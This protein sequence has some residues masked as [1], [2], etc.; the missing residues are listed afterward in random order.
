MGNNLIYTLDTDPLSDHL[1]ESAEHLDDLSKQF[2]AA[3]TALP[4]GCHEHYPPHDSLVGSVNQQIYSWT[5]LDKALECLVDLIAKHGNH[6][7][8]LHTPSGTRDLYVV[9]LRDANGDVHYDRICEESKAIAVNYNP[10]FVLLD[11]IEAPGDYYTA[12]SRQWR[13]AIIANIP[14][15][16]RSIDFSASVT[17]KWIELSAEL[18]YDKEVLHSGK[19]LLRFQVSGKVAAAIKK[20]ASVGVEGGFYLEHEFDTEAEANAFLDQLKAAAIKDLGKAAIPLLGTT[21]FSLTGSDTVKHLLDRGSLENV[22]A[23]GGVVAEVD[24][25]LPDWSSLEFEF[26]ASLGFFYGYDFLAKE[27]ILR[28]ESGIGLELEV[29]SFQGSLEVEFEAELHMSNQ[30]DS[31]VEASFSID[32]QGG[33]ESDKLE[34]LLPG[35]DLVS[36]GVGVTFD[37]FLALDDPE[38]REAWNNLINPTD[39][40]LDLMPFLQRAGVVARVEVIGETEFELDA[41]ALEMEGGTETRTTTLIYVKDPGEDTEFERYRD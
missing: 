9:A 18:N 32:L 25:D 35:L 39:F 26:A 19:T 31:Y 13:E 15:S 2:E 10:N 1:H 40:S 28:L 22:V 33:T 36:G 30:R 3:K 29:G 41:L 38:D 16:S 21:V 7:P 34:T 12:A 37:V 6:I 11:V 14:K 27:H 20:V 17:I 24:M 23:Y 4:Y 5:S 8:E